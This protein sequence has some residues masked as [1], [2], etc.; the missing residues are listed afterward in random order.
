[1]DNIKLPDSWVEKAKEYKQDIL[2]LEIPENTENDFLNG[3]QLMLSAVEKMLISE[4]P[5]SKA[6]E[7]F[8]KHLLNKL[9]TIQP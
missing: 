2:E 9:K 5:N 4:I 3:C 6:Q 7:P 1:M 8:I